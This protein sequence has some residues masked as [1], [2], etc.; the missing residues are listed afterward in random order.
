M[1]VLRG[2]E[3]MSRAF[4]FIARA[5]YEKARNTE[6]RVPRLVRVGL[7][8]QPGGV[9]GDLQLGDIRPAAQ[10]LKLKLEE[11][12]TGTRRQNSSE[13]LSNRKA[14][15][16]QRDYDDPYRPFFAERKRIIE[17]AVKYRL[18]A[19]YPDKGYVDRGGLMSYGT[20]LTDPFRPAVYVDKILKGAKPADLPVQQPRSSSL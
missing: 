3:A 6:G 14:E 8:R 12:E 16:G 11:I 13:R 9:L 1:P 18:P 7:L 5:N 20:E 4:E 17:L 10:A 19:I 15:A 2:R